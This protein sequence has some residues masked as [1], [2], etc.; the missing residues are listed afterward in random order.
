MGSV[1]SDVIGRMGVSV[2]RRL[3]HRKESFRLAFGVESLGV[4]GSGMREHR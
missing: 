1:G 2:W 3:S 4:V